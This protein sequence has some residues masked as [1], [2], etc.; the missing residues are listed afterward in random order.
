MMTLFASAAFA[1]LKIKNIAPKDTLV[2]SSKSMMSNAEL[3]VS[4][5]IYFIYVS[6][7]NEFDDVQ[8]L[9]IGNSK[10]SALQTLTDIE[11]LFETTENGDLIDIIDHSNKE[12]SLYKSSPKIFR[13]TFENQA[14]IR[15]ITIG[16]IRDFIVALKTPTE[17]IPK[18]ED[19]YDYLEDPNYK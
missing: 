12:I 13:I 8:L 11:E 17:Q 18:Q 6:S 19:A 9:F 16:N 7:T 1:Q 5:N 2:C 3:R 14:G 15:S 4:K 10:E